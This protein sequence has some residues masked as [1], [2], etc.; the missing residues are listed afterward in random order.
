MAGIDT[1]ILVT[2]SDGIGRYL[3]IR[4][5]PDHLT[6]TDESTSQVMTIALTTTVEGENTGDQ[7][8]A[9]VPL[10]ST[11]GLLATDLQEAALELSGSVAAASG[12]N[13]IVLESDPMLPNATLLSEVEPEEFPTLNQDTTGTAANLSGTPDLPDGTTAATQAAD[14]NTTKLATTAFVQQE[15]SNDTTKSPVAGPGSSQ[16][17]TVGNFGCNGASPQGA[18]AV[19]ADATDLAT[20][21]TLLNQ[22]RAALIAN[23]ITV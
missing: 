11:W 20:A 23:G 18:Y 10:E 2:N 1:R 14:D 9:T 5:F 3:A 21:L 16:S 6:I 8:A 17:F 12:G 19:R 4:T 13:F 22:I 15:I 7:T